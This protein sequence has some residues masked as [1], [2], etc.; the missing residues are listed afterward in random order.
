MLFVFNLF[1]YSNKA[2]PY[3]SLQSYYLLLK[4]KNQSNNMQKI[5][6]ICLN[7]ASGISGISK[8]P[9]W[10]TQNPYFLRAKG[11]PQSQFPPP[12]NTLL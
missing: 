11:F 3:E 10:S 9:V 6:L 8:V 7:S 5:F 12:D 4:V 1:K 2:L